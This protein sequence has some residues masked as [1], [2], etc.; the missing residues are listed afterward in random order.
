M[1]SG[2]DWLSPASRDAKAK[3]EAFKLKYY[4]SSSDESSESS[5]PLLPPAKKPR[6]LPVASGIPPRPASN[7]DPSP[8]RLAAAVAASHDGCML[9]LQRRAV[10]K[11][12]AEKQQRLKGPKV[13]PRPARPAQGSRLARDLPSAVPS[14]FGAFNGLERPPPRPS[15]FFRPHRPLHDASTVLAYGTAGTTPRI[16]I[17]RWR[18]QQLQ[19]DALDRSFRR[20]GRARL[21]PRA[22]A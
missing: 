6:A 22:A 5:S 9:A 18:L 19:L 13:A 11:A 12:Y 17:V 16:Y 3:F 20:F 7:W 21:L 8:R 14:S 1:A 10:N 4:D 2:G 15:S